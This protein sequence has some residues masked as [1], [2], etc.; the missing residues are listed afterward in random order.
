MKFDVVII[1]SG[2]GGLL[3][4][5]ILSKEGYSVCI[6]E[7]NHKPGGSLQTFGRKATIFNT[8]LN[9][10]ESL[11]EGQILSQYFRYFGIEKVKF[12]RLDEQGFDIIS[13]T[14]AKYPL[15]IGHDNFIKRLTEYFPKEKGNLRTYI[16]KIRS[17]CDSIPLY[18]LNNNNFNIIECES[19]GVGAADYIRSVISDPRLQNILAGNNL[20]YAGNDK[21]TPLLI[22]SLISNSF[23]ESAW[24]VLDGSHN[25]VNALVDSVNSCG[26]RVITNANAVRFVSK[27]NLINA[28]ELKSG[29]QIEAKYFI[30]NT[31]P[32]HVLSMTSDMKITRTFS[33]RIKSLEDTPGIFSLYLVFKKNTFPYFNH[34]FHHYNQENAWVSG[35][36]EL[37]KWPQTYVLMPNA[38]SSSTEYAEG[39]SVL[40]Y[41]NIEELAEWTD[42]FTGNRGDAYEQFKKMKGITLLDS[43]EKQFPGIKSCVEAFYSST[44]LT[45]RDYTGT[46]NG[47]AYGLVKDYNKPMESVVLPRT[48]IPNLFLTGQNTNLHGILGVTISSVNACGQILGTEYLI[49]KIRNA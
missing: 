3:C 42:T 37:A 6:L 28:V 5:N 14:D 32:S 47:S 29:E 12:K 16:N 45:W 26:G 33:Y 35:I 21:K 36:Y 2:L 9:Y 18:N 39:A 25:L 38:S 34:N 30:S 27:N 20:M 23:I 10:T 7:K 8:G 17:I 22:H 4:G 43:V 48:K 15:A 40:T 11:D 44:P 49:N 24:R 1:G 31:H 19:F 41:M 46:R 13:F